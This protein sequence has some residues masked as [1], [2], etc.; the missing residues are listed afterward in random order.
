MRI[1]LIAVLA[2]VLLAVANGLGGDNDQAEAQGAGRGD[3]LFT[4]TFDHAASDDPIVHPGMPGMAHQNYGTLTDAHSFAGAVGIDAFTTF[5]DLQ[6]APST[7]CAEPKNKTG[8]WP[9]SLY[10]ASGQL[11]PFN[12]LNVYYR[13]H[14]NDLEDIQSFPQGLKHLQG[15]PNRTTP[16]TVNFM[17][18]RCLV[19]GGTYSA[20]IPKTCPAGTT[21]VEASIYFPACW[22]GL[23]LDNATHKTLGA[24][25]PD[26]P[27]KVPG[28]QQ[29]MFYPLAAVGGRMAC[30]NPATPAKWGLCGH[31]DYFVG[32]DD[33][34]LADLVEECLNEDRS[35]RIQNGKWMNVAVSPP[36]EVVL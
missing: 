1:L 28:I 22:N 12:S 24:C 20:Y 27:V 33:G 14:S 34:R 16:G 36:Q 9:P 11:V 30:D 31:A 25:G 10:T 4:C 6:A 18:Y 8:Y 35:C 3:F 5:P 7:T 26:F 17:T 19:A 13:D 2:G 29:F 23:E 32:W 15:D 21:G